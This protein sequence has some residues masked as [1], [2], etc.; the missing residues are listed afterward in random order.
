MKT[1]A[2]TLKDD[3]SKTKKVA[4]ADKIADKKLLTRKSDGLSVKHVNTKSSLIKTKSSPTVVTK[5]TDKPLNKK[6]VMNT[7][8]NVTVASPPSSASKGRSASTSDIKL[9]AQVKLTNHSRSRTRTIDPK[10]SILN[11]QKLIALKEKEPLTKKEPVKEPI[12]FE[13]NFEE[14]KKPKKVESHEEDEFDYES[15][16]ESYE[17]D[18]E[19]EVASTTSS[20]SEKLSENDDE[21]EVVDRMQEDKANSDF[22]KIDKERIDSGSY[23]MST[24]SKKPVTPSSA[25]YDS[26]EDTINSHD[27]GISYDDMNVMNKQVLSQ[28]THEML[29]RGEELMKKISFDELSFNIFETKPIPYESFMSLYSGQR[30]MFQASTQSESLQAVEEVQTDPIAREEAW[31]Q[32][33][34][35]FTPAGLQVINSKLYYEEKLGVGEGSIDE[36]GSAMSDEPEQFSQHIDAINNFFKSE[37][38]ATM[39]SSHSSVNST[40]LHKFVENASLTMLNVIDNQSKQQELNPSKISISRGFTQLKFNEID[41]LHDTLIQRL[42]TNTKINN[43]V[44]TVHRGKT[45]KQNIL[46]LWNILSTRRPLKIFSSWS[47]VACIEIH[48][49]QRDVIVGGCNDGTISLWDVQELTEWRDES[50]YTSVI[51]PCEIISLNQM[52]NDF[53]LDNVTALISLSHRDYKNTSGMFSQSQAAQICSLHKNGSIIIWTISRVHVDVEASN[54]KRSDLDYVHLKSRVKLIKSITIDLNTN[55]SPKIM[56]K[57]NV[58]RKSAFEKTRYYFENDL[59]SDKVLRELQEID[60]N[61]L[62]K[63]KILCGYDLLMKFNDCTASLNEIFIASDLNFVMAISR[64]N[65]VDKSRKI[66]TNDSSFIA[67]TTIKIHPVNTNVLAVGQA[68]GEVKFI[69]VHDED[70]FSKNTSLKSAKKSSEA[71]NASD[72]LS[73]SCAFQNILEKEKKLYNETQALNNLEADE[74]KVFL[75]NEALSEQFFEYDLIREKFKVPFDKNIFNTFEVSPGSVNSIE[76]NITGEFMFVIVGKGLR[77]FNCWMNV[78]VDQQEKRRIC[79]MKCVQGADSSEYLVRL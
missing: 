48:D 25:H 20:S 22:S 50:E 34:A 59:F 9:D 32:F 76:F 18:F 42:Y 5:A 13:I 63:P 16:F 70:G 7:I 6:N 57:E 77:I 47:D 31:T 55:T 78:E 4:L 37:E 27:S 71:S 69:K 39:K 56:E 64:L 38:V 14:A 79:D 15:D 58:K 2:N 23:E 29:K 28:R 40:E 8:H 66:F 53:A 17:S 51:R 62:K 73:K 74:L 33:P 26:I 43:L 11:K 30:N 65:L 41:F 3:K 19:P 1:A 21:P 60:T 44:V 10:D 35:K 68:N 12:A 24:M 52:S 36:T 46:C 75:V 45:S 49:Q 72:L 67:P 54:V 61:Q